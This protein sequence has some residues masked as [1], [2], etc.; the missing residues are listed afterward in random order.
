[1]TDGDSSQT[2]TPD[3]LAVIGFRKP[4]KLNQPHPQGFLNSL[5]TRLKL[6][7]RNGPSNWGPQV[8][9]YVYCRNISHQ[10]CLGPQ[11]RKKLKCSKPRG[12]MTL[13]SSLV[14]SCLVMLVTSFIYVAIRHD[15][16]GKTETITFLRVA[17]LFN[18]PHL[19]IQTNGI[20]CW[21]FV[22]AKYSLESHGSWAG[23]SSVLVI[24]K[25]HDQRK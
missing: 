2:V 10:N 17:R 19:I 16:I 23:I 22:N 4:I 3:K 25:L 5:G 18:I 13:G 20:Y 6:D 11:R 24:I 12:L 1:M 14:D 7:P 21:E 9:G 8:V 15:C